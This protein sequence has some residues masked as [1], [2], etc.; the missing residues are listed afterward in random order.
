MSRKS[1]LVFIHGFDSCRN[2][3][4]MNDICHNCSAMHQKTST[5]GARPSGRYDMRPN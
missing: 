5:A 4:N 1:Y 3:H 2:I